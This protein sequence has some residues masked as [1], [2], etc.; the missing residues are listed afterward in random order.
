MLMGLYTYQSEVTRSRGEEGAES[1]GL[2]S[3]LVGVLL[4]GRLR[5]KSGEI[6]GDQG[7][8]N[9]TSSISCTGDNRTGGGENTARELRGGGTESLVFTVD[10]Y[11]IA[12][13]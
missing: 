1:V 10:T 9:S 5:V 3:L 6:Y 4:G 12:C 13:S 2:L 7:G 8:R 11:C